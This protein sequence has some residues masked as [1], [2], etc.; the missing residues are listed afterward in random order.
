MQNHTLNIG[1]EQ[2]FFADS[3]GDLPAIVFIHGAI[4][5]HSV[6]SSQV[7]AFKNTHRCVCPDLRGH[8]RSSASSPNISFED[9]SDDISEIID[10]LELRDITLIGWSMGGCACQVF[11]T[12]F[13]DKVARLVLVDTIPQRLSDE[14]Y[15][16]GKDPESSAETRRALEERYDETREQFGTRISPE[17][18]DVARMLADVAKRTRQDVA[19]NDYVSTDARS[20]IHLLPDIT[21]PTTIIS[22][23]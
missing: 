8:G 12:R 3:G 7:A 18:P 22:G 2:I 6:W 19:I 9:H 21:L 4:M 10:Q 17:N 5:D 14:R 23:Q 20:Q 13:P 11:V 16:Y 1:S 15:P